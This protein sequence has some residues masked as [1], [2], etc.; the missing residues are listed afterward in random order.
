MRQT[1]SA[2][3][4]FVTPLRVMWAI[5]LEFRLPLTVVPLV[6]F[7]A[8]VTVVALVLVLV[9]PLA[10]AFAFISGMLAFTFL[11]L[12]TVFD[13]SD[14]H[15]HRPME[16]SRCGIARLSYPQLQRIDA[17]SLFLRRQSNHRFHWLRR[18]IHD[19]RHPHRFTD[20][21]ATGYLVSCN[22]DL[23]LNQRRQE[24]LS[25]ARIGHPLIPW[26]YHL[27][28]HVSLPGTSRSCILRVK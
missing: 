3:R 22:L 7:L 14:L 23:P 26:A 19:R 21:V 15:R 5:T 24:V 27:S 16:E 28:Y 4:A 11:T 18:M 2:I 6:T 13:S 25:S 17:A 1:S 12:V 20:L 9:F 10:F 8:P